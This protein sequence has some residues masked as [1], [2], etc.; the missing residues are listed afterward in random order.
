M[1]SSV[2]LYRTLIEDKK[3]TVI[4]D[5]LNRHAHRVTEKF[6]NLCDELASFEEEDNE[7]NRI[8]G[9]F[10][11]DGSFYLSSLLFFA[12]TK[13]WTDVVKYLVESGVNIINIMAFDSTCTKKML[14]EKVIH[15][16]D[17]SNFFRLGLES[18]YGF[19]S[20]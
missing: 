6:I 13:G 16:F 3:V 19:I 4:L 9:K 10:R 15:F 5:E 12:A 1:S 11:I 2:S 18:E 20:S 17:G 14:S 8:T 7:I